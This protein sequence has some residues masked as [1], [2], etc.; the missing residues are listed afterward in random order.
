[1]VCCFVIFGIFFIFFSKE[2]IYK[3]KLISPFFCLLSLLLPPM[4]VYFKFE[5]KKEITQ[6]SFT[7]SSLYRIYNVFFS[8]TF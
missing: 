4:I 6:Y 2:K 7:H 1:M 5:F 3:F 8:N